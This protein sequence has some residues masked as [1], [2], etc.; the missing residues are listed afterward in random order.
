MYLLKL[1]FSSATF[2]ACCPIYSRFSLFVIK[3]STTLQ[4]P[5]TSPCATTTPPDNCGYTISDK[6]VPSITTTVL[7]Q[8][9]A[10]IA[11]IP[12]ASSL[13]GIK[14]IS[15]ALY[16]FT[17]VSSSKTHP[18]STILYF[19]LY[20][21]KLPT[22]LNVSKQILPEN[23]KRNNNSLMYSI[24]LNVEPTFLKQSTNSSSSIPNFLLAIRLSREQNVFK[25]KPNGTK[26]LRALLNRGDFS[27]IFIIYCD[28]TI[29]SILEFW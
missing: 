24:P 8:A 20:A 4:K 17:I 5:K 10:S 22:S 28:A 26:C 15:A 3:S 27:T 18:S 6:D 25:S 7:A 16:A 12:K 19:D 2:L 11:I 21:S 13:E 23:S 29:T 1:Y 9:T 14:K